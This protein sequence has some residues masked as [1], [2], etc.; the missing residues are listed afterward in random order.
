MLHSLP[1]RA[2]LRRWTESTRQ[3]AMRP[4]LWGF[5]L[6]AVAAL[7][8]TRAAGQEPASLDSVLASQLAAFARIKAGKPVRVQLHDGAKVRGRFDGIRGPMLAIRNVEPAAA[9][10][11]NPFEIPL[12]GVDTVWERRRI[13]PVGAL[14][15]IGAGA[16]LGFIGGQ[17]L[18]SED[19]DG[20]GEDD[21]CDSECW[22]ISGALTA[23]GAGVGF[24]SRLVVGLF[25]PQWTQRFP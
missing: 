6:V 3:L 20:D 7:V 1:T 14:F 2:L 12:A 22:E 24:V 23:L 15:G 9:I 19:T 11:Q 16:L 21:H 5:T 10:N 17:E 8:P 13:G 4:M 18:T 25:V